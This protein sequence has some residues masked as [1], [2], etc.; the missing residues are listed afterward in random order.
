MAVRPILIYGNPVLREK[1]RPI[2]ERTDHIR[3]L[4]QDLID[5]MVNAEGVGLA[6]PQLGETLRM[7]VV[8]L[9]TIKKECYIDRVGPSFQGMPSSIVLINPRVVKQA[10]EQTGE[11]GCLSLPELH[12]KISRPNV[13]RV[14]A[15]DLEGEPLEIEGSGLLARVLIHE[16]D[17]LDGTLFID[18]LS[19]LRLQFIRGRLKKLKERNRAV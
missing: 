16:T 5:T 9:T 14:E 8:N 13:I 19:K 10:G 4:A 3:Q 1:A 11:E 2:H 17:H 15:T 18:H 7:F 12:D 6:A